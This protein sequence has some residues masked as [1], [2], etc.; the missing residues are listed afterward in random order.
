MGTK[1]NEPTQRRART[2]LEQQI[3]DV[4]R[5]TLREFV[6]Y[7]E[8]FAREHGELGTLSLRHLERLIAGKGESGTA[9]GSPRPATARLL[10]RITGIG[11]AELL[12]A[13]AVE[14]GGLDRSDG[15]LRARLA[16]SARV[17]DQIIDLLEGQLSSIRRLDRQLGA[18]AIH[19][20]TKAKAQQVEALQ[21]HSLRPARRERL[22]TL[23]A[24]ICT[25]AGWQ[26]LDAGDASTAWQHYERGKRAA[27]ESKDPLFEAHAAAEQSF[28]LLDIGETA[29]AVELLGRLSC[30]TQAPGQLRAWMAAAYGEAL[31]ADGQPDASMRALDRAAHLLSSGREVEVRPYVALDDVHLSRWAGHV[32]ARIGNS[33]ATSVL[34]YALGDLDPTFTR[35]ETGLRVDLATA[36]AAQGES[37]MSQVQASRASALADEIG[38]VRQ[39]RRAVRLEHSES[40]FRGR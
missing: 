38:S 16:V 19:G 35:A 22:A 23:L 31:A 29:S 30:W 33:E 3:R 26:A 10:E 37:K 12:A 24:E 40:G 32:L 11:I 6:A 39:K 21:R 28:V 27:R 18:A 14:E 34:S 36:L 7:A 1:N 9:V 17:D 4:R 20:E 25:L 5:E 8:R 13:P 2:V 15:E